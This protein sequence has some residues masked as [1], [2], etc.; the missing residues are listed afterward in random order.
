MLLDQVTPAEVRAIQVFS[1]ATMV[2][3]I[4][5]SV[6]RRYQLKIRLAAGIIY[7]IGALSFTIYFLWKHG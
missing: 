7:L 6:V 1:M 3:F 5:A 2:V 4:S